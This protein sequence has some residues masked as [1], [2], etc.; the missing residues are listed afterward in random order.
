[1]VTSRVPVPSSD[2]SHALY[3]L[4]TAPKGIEIYVSAK[5]QEGTLVDILDCSS[6]LQEK[7]VETIVAQADGF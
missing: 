7:L 1:M 4:K 3:Q 5:V 6:G 2:K